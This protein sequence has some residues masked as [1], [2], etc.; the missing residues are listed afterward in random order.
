M[1]A[2]QRDPGLWSF[3]SV[4]ED[5]EF[6]YIDASLANAIDG[7]GGGAYSLQDPLIIG[8]A[9]GAYVTFGLGV[10]FEDRVDVGGDFAAYSNVYLGGDGTESIVA[11]GHIDLSGVINIGV[12]GSDALTVEAFSQFNEIAIFNGSTYF[13]DPTDFAD[14]VNFHGSTVTFSGGSVTMGDSGADAFT[15]NAFTTFNEIEIHNGGAYFY[16]DVVLGANVSLGDGSND[17]ISLKGLMMDSAAGRH[18]VAQTIGGDG[19]GSYSPAI[20]RHVI[21]LS[22]GITASRSYQIVDSATVDGDRIHFT[23]L[24]PNFAI[25]VKNPG[26]TQIAQIKADLGGKMGVICERIGGSWRT[27]GLLVTPV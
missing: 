20:T 1:F 17:I 15:V 27:I 18:V 11:I 24:D 3:D 2:R 7:S 12:S 4:V 26:G 22:G 25:S 14:D 8:G 16:D 13:N 10:L 23:N 21:V 19:D 9:P 6:E 5:F